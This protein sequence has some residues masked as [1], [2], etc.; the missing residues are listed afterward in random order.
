MKYPAILNKSFIAL[1]I[2]SNKTIITTVKNVVRNEMT[3][4]I[5]VGNVAHVL[6]TLPEIQRINNGSFNFKK[7]LLIRVKLVVDAMNFSF[8]SKTTT[9]MDK[10]GNMYVTTSK[11]IVGQKDSVEYSKEWFVEATEFQDFI[12]VKGSNKVMD[13]NSTEVL[14]LKASKWFRIKEISPEF[15]DLYATL[16]YEANK[17]KVSE[18]RL[19]YFNR[20]QEVAEETKFSM[21]YEYQNFRKLDSNSRN[22]PLSRFGFAVEYGDSFE[23]F[24]IEPAKGYIVSEASVKGAIENLKTEFK[25]TD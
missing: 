3:I 1:Q 15:I 7:C 6:L 9:R 5:L 11:T 10:E 25:T 21:G 17:N 2:L 14:K 13:N 19:T 12:T 22:Y 8:D 16:L 18:D 4:D 24:L 20:L 23:K